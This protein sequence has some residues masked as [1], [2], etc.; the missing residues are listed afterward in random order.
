MSM[1]FT[2][3]NAPNPARLIESLRYLGYNNVTA[4]ADICDNCWDAE[5][6][7]IWITVE[8][9]K[10]DFT[11][12]IA[13]DGIGM[14]KSTLDQALRLGS[15]TDRNVV[16][17][18]GRFGMGLST[19]SLSLCRRTEVVT[20]EAGAKTYSSVVDVD[21]IR[22]R[23]GFF[24]SLGEADKRDVG[25]LDDIVGSL[26]AGTMV[27]LTKCDQIQQARPET[28]ANHLRKHLA[29]I[30]RLFLT[31][32]KRL[33]INGERVTAF[34]PLMAAEGGEIQSDDVYPIRYTDD[35]GK[36]RT[37]D[38][39]IRVCLL[40]DFGADGNRNREINTPNQGFYVLRNQR[41]IAAKDWLGLIPKHPD[42]NR[43]R[44]EIYFPATL[45]A[46]MGVNFTKHQLSPHQ[47]VIDK[48]REVALP[49]IRSLQSRIKNQRVKVE[50]ERVSHEEASRLIGQKANL[51][52]KPRM[53]VE[54]R[55]KRGQTHSPTEETENNS[56]KQR[57]NFSN[58]KSKE[59][60]LPCRFETVSMS[61]AG[62]IY[63]ADILGKTVVIQWNVDHVFYQRFIL[64]NSENPGMVTATDFLVY[65]L[66][67]A[68]FVY[69]HE[70]ERG[71]LENI[72]SLLSSTMRTLLS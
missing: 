20:R 61:P 11:I 65:A 21:E 41:E 10:N 57:T 54:A 56:H 35:T 40:P 30:Y 46:V 39:R 33:F 64:D 53:E 69:A 22:S 24:K 51:L 23:N 43:V 59:L 26:N 25:L 2:V 58:T 44:A 47:S 38:I 67:S 66:A 48:L 71:I 28:F 8:G 13:D 5:A 16:S 45:D 68:E 12:T 72:R 4:V 49:Q 60:S 3:D 63:N 62:P 42:L 17:D 27:S 55:T 29:R 14:D 7:T 37:E 34:D 31:S 19:A 15:L 1:S 50:D 32:G 36:E 6:Q 9:Q 52:P 18:L 70:D